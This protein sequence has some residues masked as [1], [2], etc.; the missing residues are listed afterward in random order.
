MEILKRSA[1]VSTILDEIVETKCREV[2]AGKQRRSAVELQAAI[3][4][5]EPARDFYAAIAAEPVRGAH[6]IAEIKKK[7][8]SAGLIREDFD[9][10]T[11]ARIYRES[12]AS[13]LSVL[14]D[15][16]YFDGRLVYINEVK[17]AIEL[18]VL[19]KDFMVDPWQVYEARAGGADAILLIG[20]VLEPALLN[21]MLSLSCE[22]G[23]TSLI[24]VHEKE[25]LVRLQETIA[26]PN[27]KR[28]LLGINNR[29]L[30]VQQIE[31]E[32][33]RNLARMVPGGTILVSESGIK[34]REDV[35]KLISYGARA[36]L[37]G[38][39]LM[40]S[41]NIKSKITELLGPLSE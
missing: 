24:E 36:L 23:M 12:G 37:I 26:L 29:N 31:L 34:T 40:R 16:P 30:K 11:L 3:R 33:T 8:P 20:E 14:T 2:E 19:R 10:A 38:E 17:A 1:S 32:T 7:S 18:P 13:A 9:P 39:T 41:P 25:T 5:V 28:C 35:H 15:E 21:E 22:L 27:E 4:D 6:L